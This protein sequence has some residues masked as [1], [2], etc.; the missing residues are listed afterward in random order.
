MS[1]GVDV[2]QKMLEIM[3][4]KKKFLKKYEKTKKLFS[5]LG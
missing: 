4:A 5:D 3:Q 2:E 1:V